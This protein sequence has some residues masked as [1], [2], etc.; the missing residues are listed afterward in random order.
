MQ[1]KPLILALGLAFSPLVQAANLSDIY[2][3][4]LANDTQY[5]AARAAYQAGLEALPQARAALLPNV[6]CR[7]QRALQ[8]RPHHPAQWR[9]QQR[10]WRARHQRR[11]TALQQGKFSAGPTGRGAGQDRRQATG[12]RRP[13][14]DPAHRES[15]FRCACRRRTT[16]ASPA[17]KKPPSP[18]NWPPPSAISKSAP[19]PSSTPRKPRRATTC[20]LRRKSPRKTRSTSACV[21]LERIIGKPP[22]ALDTLAD[23]AE[24]QAVLIDPIIRKLSEAH[25]IDEWATRPRAGNLNVAD[26]ALQQDHRRRANRAQPGG[27]LPHAECRRK[28]PIQH[29]NQSLG[30]TLVDINT[31]LVGR[32]I[33]SADLSGRA[34]R[35]TGAPGRRQ[36]GKS[37]PG[38]EH[39][40]T[41]CRAERTPGLPQRDQRRR[42]STR[43]GADG[44][45]HQAA[46][47]IHPARRAGRRA[48]HAG[49]AECAAAGVFRA[50]SDWRPRAISSFW[51]GSASRRQSARSARKT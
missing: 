39:R 29:E 4:A 28:L 45:I 30:V 50:S 3:E 18:K 36:S 40:A 9:H 1:F 32:R 33:Q 21:T 48:H 11:A 19:P 44:G 37:A 16:S 10:Q 31:A 47:R 41:R 13:G 12:T 51:P 25:A 35:F 7:R 14:S 46:T 38:P 15:L 23:K 34:G 20:P 5:A 2:R 42:A 22:A 8:R 6:E 49:R 26:P 17:R 24:Q 43:A 27:A